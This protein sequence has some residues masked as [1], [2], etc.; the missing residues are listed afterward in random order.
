MLQLPVILVTN[1]NFIHNVHV[2]YS[3]GG[4]RFFMRVK[5]LGTYASIIIIVVK[6]ERN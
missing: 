3:S 5:G 2:L 6:E 1:Y 4:A